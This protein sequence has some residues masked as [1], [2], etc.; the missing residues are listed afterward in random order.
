MKPPLEAVQGNPP[1]FDITDFIGVFPDAVEPTFCD[2][3]CQY[4]DQASQVAPR[5]FTHVKDKQI[6]LDAFSPG[7][8]KGLMEYVNGCLFY[9]INEVSYLT[10][11]SYI[12]ALVL[13]QKT[14]PTQGYHMFHGENINW[15][16]SDR[17]LAW[18]VYLNDVEEGGETEWLYQQRKI[19][20]EKGTVVIWPGSFTHLHRGNP[21]MSEKYIATGWYQGNIGLPQVHTAGINDQQYMDSMAS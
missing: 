10:N 2:Y 17:T 11:F 12:S 14:E 13:L 7:E 9:Y 18:M 19:K 4:V 16:V 1:E 6:C 5:N 15:N 21:P 20:P 3:L 8:A